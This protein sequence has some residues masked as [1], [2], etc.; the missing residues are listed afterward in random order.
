LGTGGVAPQFSVTSGGVLVASSATITGAITATTGT[1]TGAINASGGE[2]T[3]RVKAGN[4]YFGVGADGNPLHHGIYLDST[5]HWYDSGVL[6]TN[7]ITAT[8][9]T[10][11]GWTISDNKI[12]AGSSGMMLS[13]SGVISASNFY[14]DESGNV[15]ASNVSLSG[16]I[17][18]DSLTANTTGSIA[19]WGISP[20]K[21]ESNTSEYRG[22]KLIPDDKIVGYGNSAHT[23]TSVVGQFSFGV[24]PSGGGG[25]PT[26]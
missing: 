24:A 26:F 13:G 8:G 9:G 5:N 2:F 7:S 23:N 20:T 25:I 12:Q 14:V 10:V 19:G 22:L 18:A 3:G 1:F 6:T 15:T 21:L 4:A 16:N 11:G 17:T